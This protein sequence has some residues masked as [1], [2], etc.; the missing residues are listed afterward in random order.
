MTTVHVARLGLFTVDANGNRIDKCCAQTSINDLK[1]TS[2][3]F[4]VLPDTNIPNSVG[5]PTIERYLQLEGQE[6]YNFRH[7]DQSF[8]ITDDLNF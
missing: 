3:A 1:S 6:G 5:Y 2:L 7:L 4:L 8:V